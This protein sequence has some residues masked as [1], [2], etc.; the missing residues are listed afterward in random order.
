MYNDSDN[1]YSLNISD[2][3]KEHEQNGGQEENVY[4]NGNLFLKMFS[5][6]KCVIYSSGFLSVVDLYQCHLRKMTP[7]LLNQTGDGMQIPL[8]YESFQVILTNVE[9]IKIIDTYNHL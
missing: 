8:P 6:K 1:C 3:A 9:V 5:D 4:V 2:I 7:A